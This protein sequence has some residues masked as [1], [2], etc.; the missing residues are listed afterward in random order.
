MKNTGGVAGSE[1][2]QLYIEAPQEGIHRPV[3]ELKGFCKLHL[4]PGESKP[5]EFELSD[6]S[7]AIWQGG[8]VV[9]AGDYKVCVGGSSRDLPLSKV[10]HREGVDV[11]VPTWQAGSFYERCAGSPNQEEF[12]RVIGRRYIPVIPKKGEYTMDNTILEMRDHS[13]VMK[14]MYKK[15]ERTIVKALGGKKDENNPEFRIMMVGSVGS[16][17]RS[18]QI[19]GSIRDGIMRG[20]LDMANGRFLKGIRRMIFG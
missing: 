10:I 11:S 14:I 5:A 18:L 19:S 20:L 13:F 6:R 3:R 1:V 17:L 4:L 7:F 16:P 2:A 15:V 12:E 9:P 8:W